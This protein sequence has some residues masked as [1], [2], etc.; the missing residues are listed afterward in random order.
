MISS[1]ILGRDGV[2]TGDG[3]GRD[4]RG[5]SQRR[6]TITGVLVLLA[7]VTMLFAAFTSAMV[8]RRGL[9][10][11]WVSIP[12]PG[13]LW[14]NTAVLIASSVVIEMARKALRS[15]RRD[16]FNR[17]WSVATVLGVLFL[18]GQCL[19]WRSLI[20]SGI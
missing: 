20:A 1:Q 2:V 8:V 14:A 6:A 7:A 17:Y 18:L 11:D 15:S 12:L 16:E 9:A 4:G 10:G 5:G 19:A 3:G 13:I